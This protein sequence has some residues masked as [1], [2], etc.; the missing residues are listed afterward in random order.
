M[1]ASFTVAIERRSLNQ[2][3][4]VLMISLI[5]NFPHIARSTARLAQALS[6]CLGHN[7]IGRCSACPTNHS[8][9]L[10]GRRI[11]KSAGVFRCYASLLVAQSAG[12]T[13][14]TKQI[15]ALSGPVSLCSGTADS[16]NAKEVLNLITAPSFAIRTAAQRL[17]SITGQSKSKIC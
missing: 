3:F 13:T 17:R 15:S 8:L 5:R 10:H 14:H 16:S 12:V 11:F 7:Q 6:L 4:K 9:S 1:S 2:L